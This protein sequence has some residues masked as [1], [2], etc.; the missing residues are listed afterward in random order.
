MIRLSLPCAAADLS[1]AKLLE[2][3]QCECQQPVGLSEALDLEC[4]PPSRAARLESVTLTRAT[5]DGLTVRV[6]YQVEFSEF[7]P[8]QD[9]SR[10]AVFDRQLTGW[11][12]A[13]Q[14]MFPKPFQPPRRDSVDE[15]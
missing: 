2:W 3:L 6:H 11:I 14:L 9:I 8:C 15:F 10:H 1:A 4:Q 5:I 7:A 12:E 13:T